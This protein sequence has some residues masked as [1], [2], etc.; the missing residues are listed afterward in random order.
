[1]CFRSVFL[2]WV[3]ESSC[4][5]IPRFSLC[6][7]LFVKVMIAL[8]LLSLHLKEDGCRQLEWELGKSVCAWV[9]AL[10]EGQITFSFSLSF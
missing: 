9:S 1:M 6:E 5:D 2:P 10:D 7:S 8:S 4:D 3:V